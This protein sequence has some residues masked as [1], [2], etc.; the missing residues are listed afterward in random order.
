MV[1]NEEEIYRRLDR[2]FHRIDSFLGGL[3]ALEVQNDLDDLLTCT[4]REWNDSLILMQGTYQ[5]LLELARL[6]YA[7]AIC[8]D[9][10]DEIPREERDGHEVHIHS[11]AMR[12]SLVVDHVSVRCAANAIWGL[13]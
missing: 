4:A 2:R 1:N 13:K 8:P 10:N 3:N 11:Q 12:D 7:K 5:K 9:C 6:K